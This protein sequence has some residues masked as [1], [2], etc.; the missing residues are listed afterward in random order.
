MFVFLIRSLRGPMGLPAG[1]VAWSE[2]DSIK[3]ARK[4]TS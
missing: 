2:V 3:L 1:V 4:V